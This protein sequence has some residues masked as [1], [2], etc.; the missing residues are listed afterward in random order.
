MSKTI[1]INIQSFF[2]FYIITLS[3]LSCENT[4]EEIDHLKYKSPPPDLI[5]KGKIL[6]SVGGIL[7][8]TVSGDTILRSNVENSSIFPAGIFI[9]SYDSTQNKV[10]TLRADSAI[11]YGNN[12]E[13]F[14]FRNVLVI[15]LKTKDTMWGEDLTIKFTLDSILTQNKVHIKTKDKNIYGSAF[16]SNLNLTNYFINDPKGT[17]IH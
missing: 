8:S 2:T 9:E 6:F 7:K 3:L 15:N 14:F 1:R 12:E 17:I 13:A 11:Y 5:V 16:H 10:A 4:K